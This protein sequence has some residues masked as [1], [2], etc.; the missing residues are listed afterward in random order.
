MA[1]RAGLTG[2]ES[3]RTNNKGDDRVV[4]ALFAAVMRLCVVAV[5][6]RYC[7]LAEPDAGAGATAPLDSSGDSVSGVPV[8][9]GML[10]DDDAVSSVG[11]TSDGGA[12]R[13]WST[14]F[15]GRGG[16]VGK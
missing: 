4:I 13:C 8:V 15:G 12:P 9:S 7:G 1:A 3:R 14:G 2:R 10:S 6:P 16:T 11:L 5:S